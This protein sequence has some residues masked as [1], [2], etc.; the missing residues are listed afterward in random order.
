MKNSTTN[1]CS[2]RRVHTSTVKKSAATIRSQCRL[3]NS[4]QVVLRLRSGA[5][6]I[7]CRSRISAIVLRAI[8]CPRLDNASWIRRYPQSRFS[9]ASWTTRVS[10]AAAVLGRP[11][12]R[13]AVPSYFWAIS[14]R[15]QANKVSGVT[16]VATS[17]RSFRPNLLALAANRRR[18]SSV[19]AIAAGRVAREA[20]DSP[21][22]GNR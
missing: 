3:R 11:G 14:F 9:S 8:S 7:P 16:M 5:G 1:C 10:R 17:A 4:F 21:R 22:E 13:C 19:S 20:P 12:P 18:W 2:P 15:C 6:S